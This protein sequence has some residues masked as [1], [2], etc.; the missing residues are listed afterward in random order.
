M[1]TNMTP[2]LPS[3]S[4]ACTIPGLAHRMK[5]I[6]F[7]VSLLGLFHVHLR[8]LVPSF[9]EGLFLSYFSQQI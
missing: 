1:T 9:A 3:T 7:L 4:T 5:L 2:T 8:S 6:S